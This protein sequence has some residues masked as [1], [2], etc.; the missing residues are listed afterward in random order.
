MDRGYL[1][2]SSAPSIYATRRTDPTSTSTRSRWGLIV[3][4]AS[5]AL[6]IYSDLKTRSA[7]DTVNSRLGRRRRR[8]KDVIARTVRVRIDHPS[9]LE[10][11]PDQRDRIIDVTVE[12]TVRAATGAR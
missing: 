9:E 2:M 11:D 12:E 8:A 3:S 10:V 5:L 1:P 7:I 6:T 4:V